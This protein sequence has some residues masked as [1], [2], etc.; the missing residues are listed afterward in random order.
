M[1]H[2]FK[3]TTG[4]KK[5]Y[6]ELTKIIKDLCKSYHRYILVIGGAG[7]SDKIAMMKEALMDEVAG[8]GLYLEVELTPVIGVHTGD[9]ALLC[10][11]FPLE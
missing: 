2:L 3:K 4:K 8:A 9:G 7:A 5:A 10:S 1:F 11:V 6:Q